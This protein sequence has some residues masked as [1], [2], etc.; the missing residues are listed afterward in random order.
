MPDPAADGPRPPVTPEPAGTGPVPRRS[1]RA[2]LLAWAALGREP[3]FRGL[4]IA[5]S[6]SQVGSQITWIAMPL[7]AIGVLDA[8]PLEVGILGAVDFL[9]FLLFTLPTGVWV[10][11]LPRRRILIASDVGRALVLAAIPAAYLADVLEMWQLYVVGFLAGTLTVFFDVGYQAFLP[12]LVPRDKLAEGNSRLEV[13]RST[14]VV[15]GPGLAGFLVGAVTAPIAILVD[16]VSYIASAFFLFRIPPWAVRSRPAA[17]GPRPSFRKEITEGL[18]YFVANPYLR[19]T[20]EAVTT[21]NFAGQVGFAVYLVF[22]VRELGLSPEAIGLTVAIGGLGTVVGA[23]T[24]QGV[25][26]RIGVGAS[27]MLA[28]VLFT[29]ST[30]LVAIA[31]AAAPIPFLVASGLIQ[32]PGV[33]LINVNALSLRQAVTPDHLLGR[34]NAT[35]RW[36]AWGTIPLGALAGGILGT[37]IG[38]RE[39]IAVSAV[40]G[41]IAA[42]LLAISPIRTLREIPTLHDAEAGLAAVPA[43]PAAT[44]TAPP[45]GL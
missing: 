30:L 28:C 32:G 17:D 20:A 16:A 43:E 21:L 29:V 35:G 12:E 10:D 22:V 33:M 31:P 18:R 41:L 5:Q 39:T 37:T 14:A 44:V 4:W 2:S 19:A 13:S 36:I 9:P 8:T 26:R 7:V 40:G 1:F 34:V 38:L 11:R 25:A 45:T 6:I 3:G 27:L 42:G 24:A 15:I 23:A